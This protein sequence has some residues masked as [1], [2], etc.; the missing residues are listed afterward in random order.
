MEDYTGQESNCCCATIIHHDVCSA[1]KEHCEPIEEEREASS[2]RSEG[3]PW[4]EEGIGFIHTEDGKIVAIVPANMRSEA[5]L[6][7]TAVNS[8]QELV[9]A[10]REYI[11]A[12]EMEMNHVPS[13]LLELLKKVEKEEEER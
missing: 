4:R 3:L 10:L 1:C 5:R 9:D 12:Y 2:R 11:D 7:L 8:H 13:G 6:I